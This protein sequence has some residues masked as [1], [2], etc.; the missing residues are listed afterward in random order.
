[1]SYAWPHCAIWDD[2]MRASRILLILLTFLKPLKY[3]RWGRVGYDSPS[4][5]PSCASSISTPSLAVLSCSDSSSV[6]SMMLGDGLSA[7]LRLSAAVLRLSAA[8]CAGCEGQYCFL[9]VVKRL[10]LP[11]ACNCLLYGTQ[12]LSSSSE[13]LEVESVDRSFES[14]LASEDW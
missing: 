9:V 5:E 13:A 14:V 10:F 6:M 2:E 4:G 12:L 7:V 1:M 3:V 8:V 11:S